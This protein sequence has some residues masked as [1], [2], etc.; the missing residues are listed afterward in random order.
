MDSGIRQGCPLSPLLFA[1]ADNQLLRHLACALP[2]ARIRAHADD[3]AVVLPASAGAA[4]ILE[5]I[6]EEYARVSGLRLHHG[7]S[8]WI[9]LYPVEFDLECARLRAVARSFWTCLHA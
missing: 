6:F 4:Q 9:P 7:K 5:P 8:H 3:L 1:V 2:N